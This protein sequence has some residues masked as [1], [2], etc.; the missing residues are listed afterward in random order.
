MNTIPANLRKRFTKNSEVHKYNTRNKEDYHLSSVDKNITLISTNCMGVSKWN[1]LPSRLKEC[2]S[3]Y[4]F[5]KQLT[6]HL[7][8]NY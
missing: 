5:K 3:I 8:L 6:N 2:I 4:K 1:N 7:M